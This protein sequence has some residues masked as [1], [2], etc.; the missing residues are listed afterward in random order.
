MD[1]RA[2]SCC[3]LLLLRHLLQVQVS[4]IT[5]QVALDLPLAL[6]LARRRPQSPPLSASESGTRTGV[7][8]DSKPEA[9]AKVSITIA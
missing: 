6:P 1:C 4:W 9:Q 7:D 8:S 2:S 5:G 3:S